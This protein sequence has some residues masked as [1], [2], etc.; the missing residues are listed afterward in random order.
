MN[1]SRGAAASMTAVRLATT[2]VLA[3][4]CTLAA[5][6]AWVSLAFSSIGSPG[7]QQS[8]ARQRRGRAA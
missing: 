6:P 5:M 2:G 1:Y 4:I 3:V 8:H 7:F